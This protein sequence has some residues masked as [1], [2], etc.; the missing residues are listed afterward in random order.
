MPIRCKMA[1]PG[2]RLGARSWAAGGMVA[3][4]DRREPP[5]RS[6]RRPR[7]VVAHDDTN[8]PAKGFKSYTDG[9]TVEGGPCWDDRG[10]E[11]P[12]SGSNVRSGSVLSV[13][14][15][16]DAWRGH[17]DRGIY[18]FPPPPRNS[19]PIVVR[20]S[21]I[22]GRGSSP[23]VRA[24]SSTLYPPFSILSLLHFAF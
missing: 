12:T 1:A 11:A 14:G 4:S 2:G 22:V 21:W 15:C 20:W 8:E 17:T 5:G 3:P 24:P 13:A 19:V 9:F 23:T 6:S 7:V 16:G 18:T 10:A